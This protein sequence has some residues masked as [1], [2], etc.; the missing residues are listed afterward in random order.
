[1][2]TPGPRVP[3]VRRNV[4]VYCDGAPV[5]PGAA[6]SAGIALRA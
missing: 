3:A 5:A 1:V 2:I 6:A 4:V